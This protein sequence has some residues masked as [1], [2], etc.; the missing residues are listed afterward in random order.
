MFSGNHEFGVMLDDPSHIGQS[1]CYFDDLWDAG[2]VADLESL[3][4]WQREVEK[5]RSSQKKGKTEPLLPDFGSTLEFSSG[6]DPASSFIGKAEA[7]FI[8]FLG[9]S[10]DRVPPSYPVLKE[11]ESSGCHWALGFPSNK[12]P[13]GVQDGSTMFIAR[14]TTKGFIVF[15]RAIGHAFNPDR[16]I[17]SE[18]DIRNRGWRKTW[19]NYIRVSAAEFIKGELGFGV[20]FTELA[21][22]FGYES[23]APTFRNH[24]AGKGNLNPNRSI[25]QKA[26]IELTPISSAWLNN[27]LDQRLLEYGRLSRASYSKFYNPEVVLT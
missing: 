22:R 1:Q 4:I 3:A 14:L 21:A 10:S 19:P 13:I 24:A 16:D 5:A 25:M 18:E 17:A 7:A 15:G 11:V 8:K 9:V 26:A 27:Q 23:L 2:R 12:R 20:P 6:F